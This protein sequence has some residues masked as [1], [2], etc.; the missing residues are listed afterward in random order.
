MAKEVIRI[1]AKDQ[2]SPVRVVACDL[3]IDYEAGLEPVRDALTS[4]EKTQT[5]P[6]CLTGVYPHKWHD[7]RRQQDRRAASRLFGR[8]LSKSALRPRKKAASSSSCRRCHRRRNPSRLELVDD[9][10]RVHEA[11][12]AVP[13][14]PERRAACK[15][16]V[17]GNDG[18]RMA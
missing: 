16:E 1:P 2:R 8:S 12:P 13:G 18:C 15:R 11:E 7:R 3:A 14:V 5:G 6:E 17:I 4:I 9:A 10:L